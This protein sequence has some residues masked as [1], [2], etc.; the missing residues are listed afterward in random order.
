MSADQSNDVGPLAAYM[1]AE[2]TFRQ[3]NAGA[4]TSF[5]TTLQTGNGDGDPKPPRG[6]G[7]YGFLATILISVIGLVLAFIVYKFTTE[8]LETISFF[9]GMLSGGAPVINK[10]GPAVVEANNNSGTVVQNVLNN[11]VTHLHLPPHG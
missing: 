1:H 5:H 9:H 10:D 6:I 7:C 8:P 11:N 4:A 2:A 3:D